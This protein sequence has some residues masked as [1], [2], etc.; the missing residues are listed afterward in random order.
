MVFNKFKKKKEKEIIK[1]LKIEK[2]DAVKEK[3]PIHEITEPLNN[4]RTFPK[5]KYIER[6][7]PAKYTS[8]FA[9]LEIDDF[10]EEE[11]L[12]Q[13]SLKPMQDVY[14]I[15]GNIKNASLKCIKYSNV[16]SSI[17]KGKIVYDFGNEN[18]VLFNF[19]YEEEFNVLIGEELLEIYCFEEDLSHA[20]YFI[21]TEILNILKKQ[22]EEL[23]SK[24]KSLQEI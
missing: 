2:R 12:F 4:E 5:G 19:I 17:R 21:K 10:I 3:I 20:K 6:I 11:R 8:G 14:M 15:V 16:H 24:I 18:N 13:D 1:P 23:E 7:P 22:K 9:K